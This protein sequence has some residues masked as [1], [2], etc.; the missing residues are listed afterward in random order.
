MKLE[1]RGSIE[2]NDY[3]VVRLFLQGTRLLSLSSWQ[4]QIKDCVQKKKKKENKDKTVNIWKVVAHATKKPLTSKS[5][6]VI[7][8]F[9]I[10]S[11]NLIYYCTYLLI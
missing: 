7:R 6:I 3:D 5:L 4:T 10:I 1:N 11:I 9:G 8:V 2:N